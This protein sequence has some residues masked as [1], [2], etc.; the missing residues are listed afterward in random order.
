M[1]FSAEMI[2]RS[3]NF[4]GEDRQEIL[5]WEVRIYVLEADHEWG[6]RAKAEALGKSLEY[7]YVSAVNEVVHKQF[8]KCARVLEL[9]NDRIVDQTEVFWTFFD[10]APEVMNEEGW[11]EPMP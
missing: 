1:W 6:A 8:M 2:F 11:E 9:F 5:H 10:D 7:N 3:V 4:P